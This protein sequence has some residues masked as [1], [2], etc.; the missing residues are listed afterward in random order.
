MLEKLAKVS[1]ISREEWLDYRREGIGGS[2]AAIIV[3]L[4][5]FGSPLQLWADKMG[6][7]K[8]LE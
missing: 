6:L 4:N 5:R 1:E 2:E 8:E 7:R 3:G